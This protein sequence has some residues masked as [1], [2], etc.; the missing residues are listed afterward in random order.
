MWI[1]II[2]F[3]IFMLLASFLLLTQKYVNPYKLIMIFG[4][5]GSGK[6]TTLTKLALQHIKKGWTV[7]STE[8]I[9]G[10][11]YIKP[12]MNGDIEINIKNF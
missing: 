5:K 8:L 4:K 3:V 1:L 9:P 11:Y 6:S 2:I 10:T 12:R 7:Y